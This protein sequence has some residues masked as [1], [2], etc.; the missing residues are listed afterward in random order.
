MR[1]SVTWQRSRLQQAAPS[2]EGSRGR[3]ADSVA[4]KEENL[5]LKAWK[6]L[7]SHGK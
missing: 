1:C 3:G 4:G 5:I 6:V 2:L 7:E